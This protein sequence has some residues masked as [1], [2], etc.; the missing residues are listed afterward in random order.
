MDETTPECDE[1]SARPVK[2]VLLARDQPAAFKVRLEEFLFNYGREASQHTYHFGNSTLVY[3]T[4]CT[5]EQEERL[6]KTGKFFLNVALDVIARDEST[7]AEDIR[8]IRKKFP[9]FQSFQDYPEPLYFPEG[10][11]PYVITTS[12]KSLNPF[13]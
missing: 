9:E 3:R 6:E 1:E 5:R 10:A 7:I 2:V 12:P 4:D 13:F 8:E 11:K